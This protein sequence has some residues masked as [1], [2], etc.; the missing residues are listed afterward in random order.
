M[1]YFKGVFKYVAENDLKMKVH[2]DF[3]QHYLEKYGPEYKKL[4][5]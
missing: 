4:S 1:F 2:C 3:L 5:V